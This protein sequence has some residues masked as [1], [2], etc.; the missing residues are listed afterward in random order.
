[1]AISHNDNRRPGA[2]ARLLFGQALR[3][4][5]ATCISAPLDVQGESATATAELLRNACASGP[6]SATLSGRLGLW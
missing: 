4:R 5:G 1:M 3:E 2:N 6:S